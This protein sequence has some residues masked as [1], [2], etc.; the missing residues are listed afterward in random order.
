[1]IR[2]SHATLFGLDVIGQHTEYNQ[3][4]RL[5]NITEATWFWYW[6]ERGDGV[7]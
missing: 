5:E 7:D 3:L 6:R 1:M 2:A 4:A